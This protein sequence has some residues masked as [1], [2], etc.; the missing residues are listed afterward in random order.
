[1]AIGPTGLRLLLS[2]LLEGST[3]LPAYRPSSKNPGHSIQS[4]HTGAP[5]HLSNF[6]H[7]LPLAFALAKLTGYW[8]LCVTA[9]FPTAL[10]TFKLLLPPGRPF[11]PI[12]CPN[13]TNPCRPQRGP[14]PGCFAHCP[15]EKCWLP[16]QTVRGPSPVVWP[17]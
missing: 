1:M 2:Q 8:S 9:F 14:P 17:L 7:A 5:Y 16:S 13:P 3:A 12:L 10:P 4:L 15:S 11:L 6:L